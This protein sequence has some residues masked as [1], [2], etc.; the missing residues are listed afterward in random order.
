MTCRFH[1][2][3]G[4]QAEIIPPR[5]RASPPTTDNLC[6]VFTVH[7]IRALAAGHVSAA[8]HKE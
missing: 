4:Q 2:E 8:V 3:R 7:H 6:P 5:D 1:V